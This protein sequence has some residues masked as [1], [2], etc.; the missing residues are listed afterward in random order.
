MT[1]DVNAILDGAKTELVGG[2]DDL[3][4]FDAAASEPGGKAVGIVTGSTW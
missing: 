1:V 2:A 4:A 3:T